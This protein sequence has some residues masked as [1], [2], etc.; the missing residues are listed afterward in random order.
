MAAGSIAKLEGPPRSIGP[1]VTRRPGEPLGFLAACRAVAVSAGSWGLVRFYLSGLWSRH[2]IAVRGRLSTERVPLMAAVGLFLRRRVS[3]PLLV[4]VTSI[5]LV[6][7]AAPAVTREA[8]AAP[9]VPPPVGPVN[10]N[11]GWVE[12]TGEGL[13]RPDFTSASVTARS[14]GQRVEVVSERSRYQRS[15]VNPD[16]TVSAEQTGLVRFEDPAVAGGWRM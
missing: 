4:A 1:A 3:L 10:P 16:G 11:A 5:A 8:A 7:S 12:P 6:F 14:S 9:V 13:V 15:W 2:L